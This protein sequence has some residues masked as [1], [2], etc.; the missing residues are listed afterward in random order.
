MDIDSIIANQTVPRTS[1]SLC[2][3]G[4]L[5]AKWEDL[6]RQL[7]EETAKSDGKLS[8][9]SGPVKTLA[10]QVQAVE[11]E[12]QESTITFELEAL[13]RSAWRELEVRHPA[14]DED[15]ADRVYGF[16]VDTFFDE[17]IPASLVSPEIDPERLRSILDKL[18]SAQYERLAFAVLGLNRQ[19]TDNPFSQT[20]SLIT[21]VSA[22]TSKRQS[23]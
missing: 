3:R 2:L 23:D 19:V 9:Q 13:P 1:V 12:M 11:S 6:E 15:D 22:V 21:R 4:D 20:A 17:A 16:N 10:E 18:T 14:R 8:G 7:K 5:Q